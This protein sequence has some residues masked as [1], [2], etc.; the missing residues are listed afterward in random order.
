MKFS[1]SKLVSKERYGSN[2]DLENFM[3]TEK[4]FLHKMIEKGSKHILI[5]KVLDQVTPKPYFCLRKV[6]VVALLIRI[7]RISSFEYG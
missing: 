2:V 4:I 5:S 6:L 7:S 1:K 3:P